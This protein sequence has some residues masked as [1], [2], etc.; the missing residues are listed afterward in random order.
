[1]GKIASG[2]V[3]IIAGVGVSLL[4]FWAM[5]FL[6][7]RL[8]AKWSD[9]LKPWVFAGPAVVFI[10]IFLVYPAV[11]TVW[12]SFL[13]S[14]AEDFVGLANY[15]S[16]AQDPGF[17]Q[18]I[19]NTVL[20]LLIVPA[21]AVVIGLVVAVLA[22][23]LAPGSEKWTKSMIFLPMAISMVGASTIFR[24]V[25]EY[26][27]PGQE[28]IGLLNAIWVNVF[29]GE[30][31]VWLQISTARLNSLLLMV[32][33]IWLQTGYCM[34]LL[35]AAIKAVPEETIE[36]A[37][38]DG[39]S[40]VQAFFRVVIPQIWGTVLTVFVTVFITVMKIFDIVYV[41]TGGNFNTNVVALS[42]FRE[43][44]EFSNDGRSAAIV[45]ILLIA[46]TPLMWYQVRRFRA[47]EAM[48]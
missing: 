5:N 21:S 22:D 20:W 4:L 44:F 26:K 41:M 36:A 13:D 32:I 28:Q 9:R 11:L 15:T 47:E 25:Y 14:N 19:L 27:P 8:P 6:V 33:L 39:A 46:V 37:R 23:R 17:Q 43:L 45:V 7:E 10:G 35:S 40:E 2:I 1:M 34:V 12:T 16:L 42:F 3:A 30:P 29:G 48:R 38:I 18:S 24:F 31:Q